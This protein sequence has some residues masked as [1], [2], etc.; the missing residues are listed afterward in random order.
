[1]KIIN[2]Y[3]NFQEIMLKEKENYHKCGGKIENM[4]NNKKFASVLK[5]G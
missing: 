1:M 2:A 3:K 4:I 5:N